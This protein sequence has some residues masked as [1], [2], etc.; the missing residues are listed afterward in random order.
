MHLHGEISV[1]VQKL[2]QQWKCFL[3]RM[4]PQQITSMRLHQLAQRAAREWTGSDDALIGLTVNE[5]PRFGEIV[6][7]G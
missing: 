1:G 7:R 3:W 5:F 4:P 2:E 6:A